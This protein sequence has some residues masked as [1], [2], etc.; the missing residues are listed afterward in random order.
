M[1]L[2]HCQACGKQ[3]SDQAV[4]C[5]QCGHPIASSP[6]LSRPP[7]PPR[8]TWVKVIGGLAVLGIVILV[9]ANIP[10]KKE[11]PPPAPPPAAIFVVTDT[12]SDES[13]TQLGDYC[14]KVYCNY[15]NNGDGPGE[16]TVSAQL[17]DE[18]KVVARRTNQLTLLPGRSQRLEF[19][20]PEAELGDQHH[21]TYKCGLGEDQ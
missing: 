1:P 20:F 2:I 3:V 19:S 6:A 21:Y 9:V 14:I 11:A 4:S 5:P 17:L 15:Q 8:R 18:D 7:A 13:C 10:G 12:R 16:K